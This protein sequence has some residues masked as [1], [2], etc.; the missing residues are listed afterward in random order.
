M[1]TTFASRILISPTTVNICG[2][3]FIIQTTATSYP[4]VYCFMNNNYYCNVLLIIPVD[5]RQQYYAM[6]FISSDVKKQKIKNS[7]E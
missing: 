4:N 7:G 6:I 1:Q 5:F 2:V 3:R